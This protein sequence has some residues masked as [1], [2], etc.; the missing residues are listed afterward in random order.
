[1]QYFCGFDKYILKQ[2]PNQ[3]RG[4]NQRASLISCI[5][6]LHI[7][8]QYF[9]PYRTHVQRKRNVKEEEIFSETCGQ[10]ER[11]NWELILFYVYYNFKLLHTA[12][13]HYLLSYLL[14]FKFLFLLIILKPS[15]ISRLKTKCHRYKFCDI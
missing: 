12:V 13:S 10:G 6:I 14:D 1:M 4:L 15:V 8:L 3:N 11:K 9:L 5:H 7:P 2:N